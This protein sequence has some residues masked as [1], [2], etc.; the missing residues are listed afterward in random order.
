MEFS[1][2]YNIHGE[3]LLPLRYSEEE[4]HTTL[5]YKDFSNLTYLNFRKV[6]LQ[7][8]LL[9]FYVILKITGEKTDAAQEVLENLF[10]KIKFEEAN[11]KKDIDNEDIEHTDEYEKTL[12]DLF[13]INSEKLNTKNDEYESVVSKEYNDEDKSMVYEVY[14]Q[15]IVP[16]NMLNCPLLMTLN[17]MTKNEISYSQEMNALDY[18]QNGYFETIDKFKVLKPLF[19]EVTIIRPLQ[20]SQI[21]QIDVLLD[22]SLLQ[23]KIENTTTAV[24]FIDN[25][26]K[27]SNFIKKAKDGDKIGEESKGMVVNINEIQILKDETTLD[28][29]LTSNISKIKEI[30]IKKD[31]VSLSNINF[32][33]Y[34]TELPVM[35]KPGEE[36]NLTLKVVK[37]AFLSE[38]SEAKPITPQIE[39]ASN[40]SDGISEVS[41]VKGG[42]TFTLPASGGGLTSPQPTQS[43]GSKNLNTN[44]NYMSVSTMNNLNS[45]LNA[46]KFI[47]SGMKNIYS[48]TQNSKGKG[49]NENESEDNRT[50]V[51]NL[52]NFK[53]Y[54]TTPVILN[55]TSDIFY[56]NLFMCLQVKWNN[57]INRFLKIEVNTPNDIFLHNY[58]DISLKCRNISSSEMNLCIEISDSF[59]DMKV[60][61]GNVFDYQAKNVEMI[62]SI[63]SQTKFQNFGQFNC[64]EDK[65]FTLKFLALKS[66]FCQLPSFAITDTF[67]GKRFFVVHSNKLLVKESK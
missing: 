51:D 23:A 28:E 48:Q 6:L 24:N 5:K 42:R 58:F 47:N 19:K 66:G 40:K 38:K 17:I 37:S 7:G 13:T 54:F 29:S 61:E 32:S 10:F 41:S 27:L 26:L 67:S 16:K 57:E 60:N 56:D 8:E 11:V 25:S 62:P 49:A 39:S 63:I 45:Q 1:I 3:I 36:Y 50:V 12:S 2:N 59:E 43:S 15:I 22:M 46:S 20:I 34:N 18:Y 44:S 21:K 52:E 9:K 64:N 4:A 33:I 30:Y 55:I 65:V 35:I 14:K 53:I 31:K